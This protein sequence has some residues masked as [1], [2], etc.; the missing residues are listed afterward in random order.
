MATCCMIP[1]TSHSGKGKSIGTVKHNSCCQRFKGGV[2]QK[3]GMNRHAERIF[4]AVETTLYDTTK[5]A[6]CHYVFSVFV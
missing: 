3:G 4:K 6:T 1:T 5:M 2:E